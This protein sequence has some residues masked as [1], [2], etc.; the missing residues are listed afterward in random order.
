MPSTAQHH[1]QR[2]R[3]RLRPPAWPKTA[4]PWWLQQ[5]LTLPLLLTLTL[6]RQSQ[7]LRLQWC[8]RWTVLQL[9]LELQPNHLSQ[10][11]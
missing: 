3:L 5:Q 6:M 2:Q 11:C 1:Q 9:Q 8:R 10:A 4:P 7:S